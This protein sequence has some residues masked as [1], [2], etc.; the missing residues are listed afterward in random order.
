MTDHPAPRRP[1]PKPSPELRDAIASAA[2]QLFAEHGIAATTT[3]QIAALAGTTERT[4]F[5]HYGTKDALVTSVLEELSIRAM[6]SLAFARI[7]DERPFT[8]QEFVEWHR[9]FLTERVENAEQWPDDYRLLFRGLF[10]DRALAGRY[11][12]T[13][14]AQIFEPMRAHFARMRANGHLASAL[15]DDAIAGGFYSLSLS[16]LIAR[17]ALTGNQGWDTTGN[18]RNVTGMFAGICGWQVPP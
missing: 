14:L 10:D 3:R 18:V 13:W 15:P 8:P 5:K 12:E 17:F 2:R 11:A 16:Y 6:R 1:G 4:L 9:A 7:V